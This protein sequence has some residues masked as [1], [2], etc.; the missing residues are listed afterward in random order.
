[1]TLDEA[2]RPLDS[3]IWEMSEAFQGLPDADVWVRPHP[4]LLSIGELGAHVAYGMWTHLRPALESPLIHEAARYY[5]HAVPRPFA[6]AMGAEALY[7]EVQRVH[8][9]CRD[10]VLR[11]APDLAAPLPQRNEWTWG[12]ALEYTAFH[13]AY[14]TG[15]MY[16]VRHLMGH[17]TADN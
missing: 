14:H 1:M 10:H 13:A 2:L 5:P 3:A 17:E 11:V 8:A 4:R 7:A 6:L 12:Y 9:A 15:Q 16:S